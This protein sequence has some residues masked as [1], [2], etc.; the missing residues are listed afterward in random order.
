MIIMRSVFINYS[1]KHHT[2]QARKLYNAI[3][4]VKGFKPW[5]DEKDI[6]A[7]LKWKPAVYN[8]IKECQVFVSLL[9]RQSLKGKGERLGEINAAIR[10]IKLW[11]ENKFYLV[12]A[13]I[14][15][16]EPPFKKMKE[17]DWV[18]FYPRW[19]GGL[20][21]LTRTLRIAKKNVAEPVAN[22]KNY[23]YKVGIVDIDAKIDNLSRLARQL[24]AAQ[25]FFRFTIPAMPSFSGVYDREYS[26]TQFNVE[27]IPDSY[28]EKHRY[29]E[30]DLVVFL[31]RF[32][33]KFSDKETNYM[34]GPDPRDDRFLFVSTNKLK[35]YCR[36]AKCSFEEGVVFLIAGQ[37]VSYFSS[38][39][40]HDET[41]Y[42]VMDFCEDLSDVVYGLI[43]RNF[44]NDC[45]A[46]LPNNE[47]KTAIHRLLNWRYPSAKRARKNI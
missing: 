32:P 36:E 11:P 45:Y 41:R 19:S 28:I 8:A 20:S 43:R 44:C 9:S 37:L 21:D 47:L 3:S 31:T 42:C 4:K 2:R 30:A 14:N 46:A 18:K 29:P 17:R 15:K 6:Q 39:D 38:I 1:W 33:L 35:T 22:R 13:L 24:N 34:S 26:P 7:G 27:R 40:F 25:S 10:T 12:P 23:H 5:M 16:C